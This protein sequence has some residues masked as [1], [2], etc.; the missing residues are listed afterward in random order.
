MN[1]GCF[2]VSL[3]VKDIKVSK[4]FY[5]ALGFHIHHGDIEQKWLIMKNGETNIGL[6]EGMFDKNMFTFNPGWDGSGN[7]VNPFDDIRKIQASLKDKGIEFMSE[8]EEGSQG[9]GNFIIL[10]PDGNPIMLDQHR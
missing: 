6:F 2:A 5:E 7:E 4:D 8:V 10:D 9:P 3:T 1:L